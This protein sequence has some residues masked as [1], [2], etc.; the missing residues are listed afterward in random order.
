[1]SSASVGVVDRAGP[2]AA[3]RLA[4]GSSI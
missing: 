3:G 2:P 1:M 4:F